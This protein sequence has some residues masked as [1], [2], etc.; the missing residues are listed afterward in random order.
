MQMM[1]PWEGKNM[2]FDF[3]HSYSEGLREQEGLLWFDCSG[4]EGCRLYCTREAERELKEKIAPWGVAGIH[5]IDSGDFHYITRFMT[6]FLGEPFALVLIDHHTDMQRPMAEGMTSCGGW[7]LQ[8]LED[9][10]YLEQLI[11][12]GPGEG[13]IE[14]LVLPGKSREKLL[15]VSAEALAL[16]QAQGSFRRMDKKVPVYLSLDKDVL[17]PG[18]AKTNWDQG[19]MTLPALKGLLH[20]FLTEFQV[21]GVDL[22]GEFPCRDH[23]HDF[24]EARKINGR[25]NQE[26]YGYL[27]ALLG[28]KY[29]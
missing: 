28:R 29:L 6:D 19:E 20:F 8:V 3:T 5:F 24:L 23:G 4:I 21:V 26:L 12:I 18:C 7:A 10:V 27:S 22:C 1:L 14:S 11:L 13:E 16:G 25:L 15:T 17:E 9:N 2:V